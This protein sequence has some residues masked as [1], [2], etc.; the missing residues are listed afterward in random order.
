MLIR[1]IARVVLYDQLNRRLLLVRNKGAD[2]WYPPGGGWEPEKETITQ[3]ALRE[4]LEETGLAVVL[5]RLLY[6]QE[7]H[8]KE[9]TIFF[10]VFWLGIPEG[11]F[12][13][14]SNHRDVDPNGQVEEIKWF[15]RGELAEMKVF[16]SRL[17][18]TFW[19]NVDSFFTTEDPFLG[20]S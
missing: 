13:E 8:A 17:K 7:F 12:G 6:V 14:Y 15:E 11:Q 9:D 20:V 1:I 5:K 19:T 2:Y 3:C 18:D 16:P 4:V 10:E